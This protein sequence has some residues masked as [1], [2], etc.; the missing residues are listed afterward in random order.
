MLAGFAHPPRNVGVM[1]IQP[2]MTVVDFGS[3]SGAYVLSIAERLANAGHVYAVDIQH[4][5]LRRIKNEAHKRGYKNV[6]IVWSDIEKPASSK[7]ADGLV[8]R[9]LISNLLFQLDEKQE[10]FREA[11]RILKP[12]GMLVV[13]D[14]SE[15]FGGLGPHKKDVVKKDAAIHRA[16]EAGFGLEKEF[17]AGAHHYGLIFKPV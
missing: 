10:V 2:G 8:D 6:E 17:D 5:L 11:H 4:D 16:L 9:V 14:W 13:I 12:D 7:L 15:S 1:D 3:G